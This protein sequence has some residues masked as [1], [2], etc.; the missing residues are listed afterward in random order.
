MAAHA[1]RHPL[2]VSDQMG[3]T[4]SRRLHLFLS[5][6]PRFPFSKPIPYFTICARLRRTALFSE[7]DCGCSSLNA[8]EPQIREFDSR[9]QMRHFVGGFPVVD[10]SSIFAVACASDALIFIFLI[11]YSMPPVLLG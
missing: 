10:C 11:S 2:S 5:V 1:H 8:F 4:V 9:S 3:R 7:C 6:C